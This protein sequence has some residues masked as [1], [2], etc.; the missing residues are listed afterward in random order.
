MS[1]T[2]TPTGPQDSGA[3]TVAQVPVTA[4]VNG[5]A[6]APTMAA[7]GALAAVVADHSIEGER[8]TAAHYDDAVLSRRAGQLSGPT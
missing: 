6:V 1:Q 3:R 2:A 8:H 4:G 7:G 5:F